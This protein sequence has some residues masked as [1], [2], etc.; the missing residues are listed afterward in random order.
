MIGR[1]TVGRAGGALL[2]V[3]AVVV[4]GP[5]ADAASNVVKVYADG[6]GGWRFNPNPDIATPYELTAEQRSIGAGSLYVLPIANVLPN[7]ADRFV[8]ELP[9]GIPAPDLQAVA[10]DFLIGGPAGTD[11]RARD[12]S[13]QVLAQLPESA[14]TVDCRFD[15]IPS[16]GSIEHFTTAS[17]DIGTPTR[18]VSLGASC[19]A[20][21]TLLPAGS[22]IT[23]L[24]LNVGHPNGKDTGLAGHLD[25]VVVTTAS[26][27][28]TYDFDVPTITT[29]EDCM[30]GGWQQSGARN[31]GD[32]IASVEA[33]PQA[34]RG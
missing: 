31:Q 34:R 8:A 4:I 5:P 6:D 32:C 26:G 20:T 11:A 9:L 28:T 14:R 29:R 2:A 30:R 3:L 7:G 16:V 33:A 12:F 15:Y 22:T 27:T 21:P 13:L 25:N 10:Y 1:G 24:A 23:A 19:P 18:S 17:F